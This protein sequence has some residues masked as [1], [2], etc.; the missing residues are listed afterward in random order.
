MSSDDRISILESRIQQL[1]QQ[2]SQHKTSDG[3]YETIFHPIT[4]VPKTTIKKLSPRPL[5][6]CW[7]NDLMRE[8]VK[9]RKN[10][11]PVV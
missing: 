8:I 2:Y 9:R 5:P 6:P 11:E 4:L 3:D 7:H 1:E 10:L